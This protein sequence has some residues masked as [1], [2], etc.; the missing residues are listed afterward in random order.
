LQKLPDITRVGK[1]KKLRKSEV[2]KM[3]VGK[4]RSEIK[5]QRS[6]VGGEDQRV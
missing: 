5:G 2:E 3:E 4:R 6:D 1:R